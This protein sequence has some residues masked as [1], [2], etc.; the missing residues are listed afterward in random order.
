MGGK[1]A[2][3]KFNLLHPPNTLASLDSSYNLG[4]VDISDAGVVVVEKKVVKAVEKLEE[5]V[6][7]SMVTPILPMRLIDCLSLD[8]FEKA[9]EQSIDAKA[10]A[11]YSSAADDRWSEIMLSLFVGIGTD[12]EFSST[13]KQSRLLSIRFLPTSSFKECRKN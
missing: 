9:A 8:D 10:W 1:D 13:P 2:T 7:E 6:Q 4:P 3:K 5:K 11:W 12:S